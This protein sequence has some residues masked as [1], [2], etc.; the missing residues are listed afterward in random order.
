MLRFHGLDVRNALASCPAAWLSRY[1]LH[2]GHSTLEIIVAA[3]EAQP[4]P[5]CF[6][7]VLETRGR[8]IKHVDMFVGLSKEG[9]MTVLVRVAWIGHQSSSLAS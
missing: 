4:G 3:A 9:P 1:L 5:V 7:G 8:Q 2:V 6:T